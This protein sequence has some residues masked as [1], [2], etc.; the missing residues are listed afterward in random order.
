MDQATEEPSEAS[1]LSHCEKTPTRKGDKMTMKKQKKIEVSFANGWLQGQ[2]VTE[3]DSEGERQLVAGLKT[4]LRLSDI[5]G[6][7]NVE[8]GIIAISIRYSKDPIFIV[9]SLAAMDKL[10]GREK[11]REVEPC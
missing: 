10:M 6:Y 4:R 11:L 5:W 8:P 9:G 2:E 7:Q 1:A 3:D